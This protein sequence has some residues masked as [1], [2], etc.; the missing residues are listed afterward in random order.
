M[1]YVT[2]ESI[3]WRNAADQS[4]CGRDELLKS[5]KQGLDHNDSFAVIGQRG[6]GKSMVLRMI[7][8]W[9][10]DNHSFDPVCLVEKFTGRESSAFE[11]VEKIRDG[12]AA[13][14]AQ[15]D[16]KTRQAIVSTIGIGI[17]T[18]TDRPILRMIQSAETMLDR[19]VSVEL[20]LDDVH[21]LCDQPWAEDLLANLEHELFSHRQNARYLRAVFGGDVRARS[22]LKSLP[23]S[24]LWQQLREV[25]LEPLSRTDVD[26]LLEHLGLDNLEAVSALLGNWAGGHPAITQYLLRDLLENPTKDPTWVLENSSSRFL[27]ELAKMLDGA[28]HTLSDDARSLVRTAMSIETPTSIQ[29]L[30]TAMSIGA[31]HRDRILREALAGGFVQRDGDSILQPGEVMRRWIEGLSSKVITPSPTMPSAF[32]RQEM[33][34]ILPTIIHITDLHFG[35][36]GHAWDQSSEIPGAERPSHDRVTLLGTLAEDLRLL[37]SEHDYLWP[38][39]VIVS[40]DL[41]FQCRKEGIPQAIDFLHGLTDVLGIERSSVVLCPGNHEQNRIILAEEPK[42]QLASYVELWNGFYPREFR[43]LSLEW[44]PG[45]YVHVFRE[46]N[47]EILSLNSCEDLDSGSAPTSGIPR[48]QGYIGLQQLRAA[49]KLLD[50][51]KPPAGHVRIAVLHHHLSQH[52][53]TSGA[54]YSILREVERVIDWLRR[55]HFD[56]VFHGHQHCVGLQTRVEAGRY[57]TILAG[58]SAGVSSKYRWRGGMPLMY[59][60]VY[61]SR[62]NQAVRACR[63]FDLFTETWTANPHEKIQEFPLG[64]VA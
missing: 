9:R 64:A 29:E 58:G 23:F 46:K 10:E 42:A 8:E 30:A 19:P 49:E 36:E 28:W 63:S 31:S 21:R 59:Q 38:K 3:H 52:R 34:P 22:L 2:K 50:A 13:A 25:W 32:R 27:A 55:F 24:D 45:A 14:L 48:E 39:V 5:V 57:L 53:W 26:Q 35:G 51:E 15:G 16:D 60:L 47:L 7:R 12:L 44:S 20:L 54:D 6:M 40:G 1:P 18:A 41:L 61:S 43:R 37:S 56:L 11:F 33:S 17:T 4:F 62:P